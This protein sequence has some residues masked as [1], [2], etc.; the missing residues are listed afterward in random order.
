MT[1]L[2]EVDKDIYEKGLREEGREE[3]I[4]LSIE[5]LVKKL[6]ISIEKAM[7]ILDIPEMDRSIY[8]KMVNK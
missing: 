1:T 6:D 8:M 2:F 5:K 4:R 7:D 3:G